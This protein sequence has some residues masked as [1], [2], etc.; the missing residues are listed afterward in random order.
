MGCTTTARAVLLSLVSASCIT[1]S[2]PPPKPA[3]EA[4]APLVSF[5]ETDGACADTQHAALDF[6]RLQIAGR[7]LRSETEGARFAWGGTSF[8]FRF[9]GPVFRVD[10][11]DAGHNLFGVSLD[12]VTLPGKLTAYFGRYCYTL[13]QGLPAGEHRLT[14]TR[15]TEAS[16]GESVLHAASLDQAGELLPPEPAP[17]R[18]LEVIGDSITAAYGVEGTDRFCHFTPTTENHSLSYAALLATTLHAQLS[19]VAWSGKGVFSNAGSTS[20]TIPMPPLWERT[21]PARAGSSWDFASWQPDAVVIEL[22]TNDFSPYNK[23]QAPFEAA[24]RAFLARVREVYPKAAVLCALSPVL[25]DSWP[26][27]T[28]TRSLARER[29]QGAVE[30]RRAQGDARVFYVEHALVGDS[31]GFGC[32]WHPSR[33]THARMARELTSELSKILGW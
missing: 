7:A 23:Q 12:G 10:L 8:S 3:A 24:Y 5:P 31:E 16:L 29:I 6:S 9:R 33:L 25:S 19:S 18:R 2:H 11:E 28:H 27:G 22:G 4:S 32:D 14:L 1:P 30:F 26:A 15:L 20:D 17:T 13:A 21:L